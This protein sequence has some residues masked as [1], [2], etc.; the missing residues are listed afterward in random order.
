MLSLKSSEAII[1]RDK[2]FLPSLEYVGAYIGNRD[3]FARI[4]ILYKG[5]KEI[6]MRH[7]KVLS[8]P[9]Q[10]YRNLFLIIGPRSCDGVSLDM[11]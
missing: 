8:S 1:R 5:F 6:T 7:D 2:R 11:I 9:P 3:S 4:T 10:N